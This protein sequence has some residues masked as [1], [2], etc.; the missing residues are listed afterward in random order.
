MPDV[1]VMLAMP[2]RCWS[3]V[4]LRA[5]LSC[6]FQLVLSFF[7]VLPSSHCSYSFFGYQL[8]SG[9]DFEHQAFLSRL[10]PFGLSVVNKNTK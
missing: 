4:C 7:L 1:P 3:P 10:V 2:C 9:A 6:L 5:A 8:E